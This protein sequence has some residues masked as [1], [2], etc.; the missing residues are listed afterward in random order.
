ML[1]NSSPEFLPRHSNARLAVERAR[2][3]VRE[4]NEYV[5]NLKFESELISEFELESALNATEAFEFDDDGDSEFDLSK[6]RTSDGF[7]DIFREIL[8]F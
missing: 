4:N 3:T 6:I 7:S 5:G 8:N 2:E 1:E